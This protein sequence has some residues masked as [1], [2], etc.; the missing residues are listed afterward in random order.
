MSGTN[1]D[2]HVHT[3][4]II[5]LLLNP[6]SNL[7]VHPQGV[8]H[9]DLKPGNILLLHGN[10]RLAD[11]GL[12]KWVRATVIFDLKAMLAPM[13]KPSP[14]LTNHLRARLIVVTLVETSWRQGK[15]QRWRSGPCVWC[16]WLISL[17]NKLK[18]NTFTPLCVAWTSLAS[19]HPDLRTH[20]N[21]NANFRSQLHHHPK[22]SCVHIFTCTPL[23]PQ[24]PRIHAAW[25][26]C[27]HW[28]R[29]RWLA[30]T[31]ALQSGSIQGLYV[32]MHIAS[33]IVVL[34]QC[35]LSPLTSP[36]PFPSYQHPYLLLE[37][38]VRLCHH[39]VGSI[40]PS[41][42]L[43]KSQRFQHR[44]QYVNQHECDSNLL[45]IL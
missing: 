45:D 21:S 20:T 2:I 27:G 24:H 6:I 33:E 31:C 10:V 37:W 42:A 26:V 39:S 19:A 44:L 34:M 23:C 43:R 17:R 14:T 41:N 40:S 36:S 8:C 35:T 38:R 18:D 25:A 22:P 3:N 4:I 28:P 15:Q 11:F 1:T 5:D 29:S 32:Y 16:C 13:F 9:R 12:S 30:A 7:S